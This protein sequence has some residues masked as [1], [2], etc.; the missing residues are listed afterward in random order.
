MD[1]GKDSGFI[2]ICRTFEGWATP[3]EA[4]VSVRFTTCFDGPFKIDFSAIAGVGNRN[5]LI[6][7]GGKGVKIDSGMN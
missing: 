3:K 2:V 1:T 7:G 4:T 6:V 5:H